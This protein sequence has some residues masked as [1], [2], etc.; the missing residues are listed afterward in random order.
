MVKKDAKNE[1]QK[2][3]VKLLKKK[4]LEEINVKELCLLANVNRASFYAH[5]KTI[6]D[7]FN[8]IKTKTNEQLDEYLTKVMSLN[9]SK[10]VE[11]VI[12]NILLNIKEDKKFYDIILVSKVNTTFRNEVFYHIF[13]RLHLLKEHSSAKQT[14]NDIFLLNGS[15]GIIYYW[16]DNDLKDDVSILTNLIINMA[17]D[18]LKL[19]DKH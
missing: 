5:Y 12:S 11:E 14:Y 6:L 4:K 2:A 10:S 18:T 8:D 1:L 7:V 9:T 16:I 13:S 17:S 15:I 19:Q 3:L